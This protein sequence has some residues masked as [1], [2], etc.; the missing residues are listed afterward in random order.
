M[1]MM[2]SDTKGKPTNV[3]TVYLDPGSRQRLEELAAAS[4]QSK[5]QVVRGLIQAANGEQHRRLAEIA[6][7]LKELVGSF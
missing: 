2:G 6:A 4:G 5:S 1:M 7:E 3:T